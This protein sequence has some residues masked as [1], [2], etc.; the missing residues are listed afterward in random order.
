M[1]VVVPHE[2][3][4]FNRINRMAQFVLN[5]GPIFEAM[6]MN[7]ELNNPKVWLKICVYT[8]YVILFVS[9]VTLLCWKLNREIKC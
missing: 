7:K 9:Y 1:Y 8:I 2:K 6:I 3:A 5:E 4:M